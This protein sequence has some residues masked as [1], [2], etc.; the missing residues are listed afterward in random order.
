MSR[1][2]RDYIDKLVKEKIKPSLNSIVKT[3]TRK[4]IFKDTDEMPGI[5]I[6]NMCN[7]CDFKNRIMC[8]KYKCCY[9]DGRRGIRGIFKLVEQ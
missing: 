9:N 8:L 6:F 2:K 7:N 3:R 5:G 1:I 4:Y